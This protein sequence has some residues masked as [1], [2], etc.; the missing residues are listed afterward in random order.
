MTGISR[1]REPAI[2]SGEAQKSKT[3]TGREDRCILQVDFSAV[4]CDSG[5]PCK[6]SLG[7]RHFRGLP[8][9]PAQSVAKERMGK[10]ISVLRLSL[11]AG[12]LA[13]GIPPGAP[14]DF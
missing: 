6:R 7:E 4:V 10:S 3:L 14:P 9:G 1:I 13:Q 8:K 11:Q 5:A 12:L 2:S